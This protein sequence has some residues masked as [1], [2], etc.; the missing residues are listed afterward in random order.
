MIVVLHGVNLNHLCEGSLSGQILSAIG[1]CSVTTFMLISGYY[2]IFRNKK[3]ILSL[4]NIASFYILCAITLEYFIGGNITPYNFFS[5]FF[6]IISGKYWF[7][8]AYVLLLIFAPYINNWLRTFDVKHTT[9]LIIILLIVFYGI[10]TFFKHSIVPAGGKSFFQMVCAYIIGRYMAQN[11][12]IMKQ[13]TLSLLGVFVFSIACIICLDLL[14]DHI[15]LA[16]YFNARHLVY[17]FDADSSIFILIA[18]T[19]L[20][21]LFLKVNFTNTII[22]RVALSVF[23]V[24][25]LEWYIRPFFLQRI[26]VP[27][28][29]TFMPIFTI[30]VAAGIFLTCVIINQIRLISTSKLERLFVDFECKLVQ[31]SKLHIIKLIRIKES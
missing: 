24:Y 20:L 9:Y 2:G 15:G 1:N 4:R 25:I 23:S 6:P 14:Q 29:S 26:N 30:G 5:A 7:L 3:K 28:T 10:P 31:Q 18:S 17:N 21:A 11:S 12:R 27:M 13:S 8:T 16:D 19:C 22:N